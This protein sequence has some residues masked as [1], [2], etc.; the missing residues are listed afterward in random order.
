MKYNYKYNY[1]CANSVV[2]ILPLLTFSNFFEKIFAVTQ[3]KYWVHIC[4]KWKHRAVMKF[5]NITFTCTPQRDADFGIFPFIYF[6]IHRF[7]FVCCCDHTEY[8][9]LI[10][11]LN[12][13]V[14]L[15]VNIFYKLMCHY[16]LNHHSAV[17]EFI[18]KILLL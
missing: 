16:F 5:K 10:K 18:S 15:E 8:I 14:L 17:E 3:N 13:P 6:S 12:K 2:W 9:V 4:I 1:Y 7:Y 11:D